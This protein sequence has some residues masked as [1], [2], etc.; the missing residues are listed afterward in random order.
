MKNNLSLIKE[1][2]VLH[3]IAQWERYFKHYGQQH[4][5]FVAKYRDRLNSGIGYPTLSEKNFSDVY[6][7]MNFYTNMLPKA[8]TSIEYYKEDPDYTLTEETYNR[9]Y[10]VMQEA[11]AWKK[12]FRNIKKEYEDAWLF[13]KINHLC[14]GYRSVDITEIERLQNDEKYYQK[15]G[16]R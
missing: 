9:L 1:K 15:G 10:T 14:V 8:I 7:T 12:Q 16:L 2:D 4:I 3:V 11:K 6:K 5:D 13:Y